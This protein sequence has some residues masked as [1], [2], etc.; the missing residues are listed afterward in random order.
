MLLVNVTGNA[1]K[2]I[3]RAKA[4]GIPKPMKAIRLKCLDCVCH[5]E[6]LIRE[7]TITT[8]ALWPYRMGRYPKAG[9]VTD[10]GD[11]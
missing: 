5:Q 2:R 4:L 6:K 7:C 3:G 1:G 8:C 11:A 9:T 10:R